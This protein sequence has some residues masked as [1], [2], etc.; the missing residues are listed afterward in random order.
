[1]VVLVIKNMVIYKSDYK[2]N[3]YKYIQVQ[4]HLIITLNI[5]L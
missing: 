4:T 1:M 2:S 5:I 3:R